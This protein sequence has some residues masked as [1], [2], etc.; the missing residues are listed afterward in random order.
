MAPLSPAYAGTV[1]QVAML[2][3]EIG[4]NEAKE[5]VKFVK[6]VTLKVQVQIMHNQVRRVWMSGKSKDALRAAIKHLRSSRVQ[7][8][9]G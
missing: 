2:Q 7:C 6:D 4:N 9:A 3:G 8:P 1:R 5:P